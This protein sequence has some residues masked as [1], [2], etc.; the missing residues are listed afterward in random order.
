MQIIPFPEYLE[1]LNRIQTY[2][3]EQDI[4]EG[5]DNISLMEQGIIEALDFIRQNPKG[6]PLLPKST[7]MR[8]I[9]IG[10]SSLYIVYEYIESLNKIYLV[11]MRD[12]SQ[13]PE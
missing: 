9:T 7:R 8:P 12:Y 3:H 6:R 10:K 11:K 5:T 4:Y 2:V 1:D 13:E